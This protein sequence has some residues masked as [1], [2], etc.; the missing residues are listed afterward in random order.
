M[1]AWCAQR[2]QEQALRELSD[3]DAAAG[4]VMDMRDIAE[5]PHYAQ[6][7]AIITVDGTPMQGL[8]AKLSGTPGAVHWRGKPRDADGNDIRANGWGS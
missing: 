7:E 4:P 5:D 8:I 3:A 6:R 2:T 1:S